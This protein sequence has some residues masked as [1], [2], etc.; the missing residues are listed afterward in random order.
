MLDEEMHK[1]SISQA[2]EFE[3]NLQE[4][5]R[6]NRMSFAK[7]QMKKAMERQAIRSSGYGRFLWSSFIS[8]ING[9][10][11]KQQYVKKLKEKKRIEKEMRK[12]KE[13]E[14][15]NRK[16]NP[17]LE[18]SKEDQAANEDAEMGRSHLA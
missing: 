14:D 4:L 6:K 9:L 1:K 8:F 12:Q 18:E 11:Q 7:G 3:R 17:D 5:R 2:L 16:D 13:E 10:S 15:K